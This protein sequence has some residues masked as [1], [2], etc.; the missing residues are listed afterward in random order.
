MSV[1][2]NSQTT[3]INNIQPKAQTAF[4]AQTAPVK[5]YPPDT[6]AIY[7]KKK[8]KVGLG[9]KIAIGI[10]AT[11]AVLIGGIYAISKH[12]TNKLQRLYKEKLV[13]KIFDKELTFIEAKTKDDALKYAKDVLGVKNID[14]NMTLEALNYTNQGI[15]NVVNKNIG[16]EVFI[17][18]S[19]L[20]D[21]LGNDVW[22]HVVSNIKSKN[23]V[24]SRVFC[25]LY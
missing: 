24:K 22:A 15:T 5:D 3:N 18:R 4:R 23:S 19:Y 21:D 2:I 14:T 9:T 17:P 10:G 25:F 7:S 11:L 16:Q 6:V 12:Q 13:P 1:S 8:K 20:Y